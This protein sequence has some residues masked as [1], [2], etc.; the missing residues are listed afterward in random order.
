MSLDRRIELLRWAERTG[1]WIVEDDYQ[2][3]FAFEG[4][5]VET[6]QRLDGGQRVFHIGTFG[7]ALFPSLRLAYMVIPEACC[8]AFG[9]VR[10]QLDDHTHGLMQ[11]VLADFI[12]AGE[13]GAHLRR[14]GALYCE[15][16]RAMLR[17][18]RARFAGVAGIDAAPGGMSLAL[19]LREAI[20]DRAL[21][22][23]GARA[24]L[25]LLPLSRYFFG[26]HKAS[27]LLLGYAALDEGEIARGVERLSDLL[28][29]PLQ[30][31]DIRAPS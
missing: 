10:A 28:Q 3:E 5:E 12:D 30:A 11:A 14:M 15:R 8:D 23:A 25:A 16:R 20:D 29:P 19:W 17:T 4:R 18:C 7:N 1:A 6:L 27:G 26:A 31:G 22:E 24:G 2:G 21:C 9:A 13:F